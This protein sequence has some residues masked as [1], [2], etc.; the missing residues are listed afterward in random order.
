MQMQ[1]GLSNI[2]TNNIRLGCSYRLCRHWHVV[3]DNP[4]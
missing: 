1:L 4:K 3:A 2:V